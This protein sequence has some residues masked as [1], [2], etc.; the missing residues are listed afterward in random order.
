MD[1]G[2]WF[3]SEEFPIEDAGEEDEEGVEEDEKKVDQLSRAESSKRAMTNP[4]SVAYFLIPMIPARQWNNATA[5]LEVV[6]AHSV[7]KMLIPIKD[8]PA[9]AE[10]VDETLKKWKR[11]QASQKSGPKSSG[12]RPIP[13]IDP[14]VMFVQSIQACLPECFVLSEFLMK[15][16]IER[17]TVVNNQLK[18]EYLELREITKDAFVNGVER[19]LDIGD[20]PRRT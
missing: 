20:L 18:I 1:N 12:S 5:K 17:N 6:L 3:E 8:I 16:V 14:G 9:S 13:V 10:T 2:I 19:D 11:Y 4:L 7:R 15:L